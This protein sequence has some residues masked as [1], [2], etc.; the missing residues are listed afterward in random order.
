[1]TPTRE[2]IRELL[3][4]L[5]RARPRT[6]FWNIPAHR[7]PT[8]KLYRNL[9]R[10]APTDAIHFRIRLLWKWNKH[11][12][13]VEKTRNALH[14]GYKYL[15]IFR[16]ANAGD[17]RLRVLL[18][19]YSNL[20]DVRCEKQYWNYLAAKEL[21]WRA[22][23]RY[24]PIVTGGYFPS[25]IYHKPL[26]RMINQPTKL[27]QMIRWRYEANERRIKR[28]Q[29][30]LETIS[31]LK[32]DAR[33][34]EAA[35]K[36][37]PPQLRKDGVFSGCLDDWLSP[38]QEGMDLMQTAFDSGTARARTPYPQPL[39]DQLKA[40]RKE[41][42]L[43][44]TK[45]HLRELRGEITPSL[46]RKLR[47]GPPASVLSKMTTRQRLLDKIARNPSEVGFVAI[48]KQRLGRGMR[49]PKARFVEDSCR[50][51]LKL[52]KIAQDIRKDNARKR[53]G[54]GTDDSRDGV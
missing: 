9:L 50:K 10:E 6:P 40:A 42:V 11:L 16:R 52:D 33:A 37:I 34:E 28:H 25:S 49:N 19:R 35:Q 47:K 23:L 53:L 31:D 22:K 29:T 41:R 17:T 46:L 45:E 51:R 38:Y 5:Q 4:P 8:L 14:Q 48:V 43:N 36:K 54:T 12:T 15:D 2:S 26:P 30:Y 44:K 27:S 18:T 13:S 21:V 24:R 32:I 39:L 7:T 3:Q 1:M 20:I